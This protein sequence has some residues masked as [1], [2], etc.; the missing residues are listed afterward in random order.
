MSRRR[1]GP[2][3]GAAAIR[4]AVP[5][6]AG[7]ARRR[8]RRGPRARR[9]SGR[10]ASAV[11]RRCE[12]YPHVRIDR[13]RYAEPMRYFICPNCTTRALDDDGKAGLTHQPVGCSKCGFGYLFELLEDFFPPAGA[14][15]VT[16][17]K[18]GR[19]L[20]CGK[21]VFEVSGYA[22][23]DV[24]GKPLVEA[25][26]LSRLRRRRRPGADRPGMGR[27][28]ARPAR[29][30]APSLRAA[31]AGPARPLPGLRR[32]RRHAGLARAGD[33]R[34]TS[35]TARPSRPPV[36]ARRPPAAAR[37]TRAGGC[38]ARAGGARWPRP[39]GRARR[40]P[41]ARRRRGLPSSARATASMPLQAMRSRAPS[42]SSRSRSA[43]RAR[44][45]A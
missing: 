39:A 41:R 1:P 15:M 11:G 22:E 17:D 7:R 20:S 28:Q 12:P 24:M 25:F 42:M 37:R 29:D 8:G 33:E 44:R 40:A 6:A 26:G 30:D 2:P 13:H 38:G 9:T 19:V 45:S 14:G 10:R 3:S 23:G 32:G 5:S 4:A 31:Q 43:W 36:A 21:G 16:C 35:P 18:D 34:R 27:P